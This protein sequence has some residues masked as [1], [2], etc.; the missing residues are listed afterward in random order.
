[1]PNNYFEKIIISYAIKDALCD[2]MWRRITFGQIDLQDRGKFVARSFVKFWIV[3]EHALTPRRL[4]GQSLIGC[5]L[6]GFV[7]NQSLF[8]SS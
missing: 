5:R 7:K 6:L 3:G 4:W 1:M 2:V 8:Q